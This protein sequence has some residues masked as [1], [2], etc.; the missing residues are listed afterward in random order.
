[1]DAGEAHTNHRA[2]E[3]SRSGGS[4]PGRFSGRELILPVGVVVAGI[5]ALAF[6]DEVEQRQHATQVWRNAL[7]A[8]EGDAPWE[9]TLP[10]QARRLPVEILP[11]HELIEELAATPNGDYAIEA[12]NLDLCELV[13]AMPLD[14]ETGRAVLEWGRLPEPGKPEVLAGPLCRFDEFELDGETFRV[15]GGLQ[16]GSSGFALTYVL[17]EHE[18]IRRYFSSESGATTGWFDPRGIETLNSGEVAEDALDESAV[19]HGG[20]A[21]TAPGVTVLS[22]LAILVVTVGGVL[23]HLRLFRAFGTRWAIFRPI[24]RAFARHRR[25]FYALNGLNFGLFFALMGLALAYPLWNLRLVMLFAEV[26]TEG[27]LSSIGQAYMSGNIPL[28]A[29][30]T[31]WQN[32]VMQTVLLSVLPSLVVPFFGVAKN[33]LSIG[34]AGFGIAPVWVGSAGQFSYHSITVVLELE[35]YTIASFIV[36][37][38]PV[39]LLKALVQ[40]RPGIAARSGLPASGGFAV[41]LPRREHRRLGGRHCQLGPYPARVGR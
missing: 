11:H 16:R 28:A 32:Y 24:C 27:D 34:L 26:F 1:M 35:A 18:D 7:Y 9:G 15:V 21:L 14:D 10:V 30:E 29:W 4:S 37:L 36:T 17:P 13:L 2:G 12:L 39:Y 33:A 3:P 8:T 19:V 20:P 6:I 25:L 38:Y 23:V 31:F 22:S 40:Q 5:L 41:D